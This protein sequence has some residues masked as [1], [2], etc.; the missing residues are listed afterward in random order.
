MTCLME[1]GCKIITGKNCVLI[2]DKDDEF[3]C[4]ALKNN[5][6]ELHLEPVLDNECCFANEP[7]DNYKT[8]H[9]RLCHL[10]AKY[11]MNMKDYI[12]IDMNNANNFRCDICDITKMTNKT[13]S[14]C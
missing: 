10:N 3:V 6:L 2:F 5:R 1:R 14:K 12:D 4:K 11:M 7:T 8:W 13:L 9:N